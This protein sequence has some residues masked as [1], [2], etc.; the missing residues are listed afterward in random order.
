MMGFLSCV[1]SLLLAVTSSAPPNK[2]TSAPTKRGRLKRRPT[3]TMLAQAAN[4]SQTAANRCQL[5]CKQQQTPPR[6]QQT[7]CRRQHM[8][9]LGYQS[10]STSL[11]V[12]WNT[13][14]QHLHTLPPTI[15]A[16]GTHFNNRGH[17]NICKTVALVARERPGCCCLHCWLQLW[18]AV[19]S[20]KGSGPLVM[21]MMGEAV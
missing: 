17:S 8:L 9:L 12:T 2:I 19:Q 1:M 15:H 14:Q 13:S 21:V 3:R 10:I 4:R 5:A 20:G 18:S 16:P 7:P 6:Q 11:L